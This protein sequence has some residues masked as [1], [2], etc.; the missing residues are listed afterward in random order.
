MNWKRIILVI[1]ALLILIPAGLYFGSLDWSKKHENRVETL[2]L[3]SEKSITGEYRLQA[4]G[5]E[6]LVRVAGMNNTGQ[7][8]ILLHGFPES[9]IMWD[10]LAAR[11]AQEG[12]RVVAFDQR[13]YSPKARPKEIQ[14]Y[15]L[16]KLSSDVFAVA[17]AVEFDK[18]HLV[19]HDWGA[20]VGWKSVMDKPERIQTWT[21]LSIPHVGIF[22]DGV[23]NDT[24]QAK[25]SGYFKLFQKAYLPEFLLT[26]AGQRNMKKLMGKLPQKQQAEY[27]SI[28]AE[29]NAMTATLN[30]Y[31][32][33]DVEGFAESRIFM[34]D[35][36]R[37]TLFIWGT[38]DVVIAE[39]VIA[40][41]KPFIKAPYQE[42][43]LEAGHALVQEQEK[44]VIEAILK[45]WKV[46]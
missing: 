36:T 14:D 25:R 45:Q 24:T 10:A 13:G 8:I 32:A 7:N 4:N 43:K 5:Y 29:P 21:A 26:F 15:H 35:I 6:Y 33:M 34:K 3:F 42:I 46:E 40:K 31:R 18:F 44:I 37:P 41:Q 17:D 22:F 27:F 1:F 39:S 16:D 2:P 28:L 23:I 20:A 19:G 30:W 11:A 12:Y 9:S 38:K